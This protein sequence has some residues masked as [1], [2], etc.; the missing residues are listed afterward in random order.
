LVVSVVGESVEEFGMITKE[1]DKIK[2]SAIELNISCPN[3]DKIPFSTDKDLSF[4]VVQEARKNTKL[5][6]IVKLSPNVTDIVEIAHKVEEAGADVINA[7][8]TVSGMK[9]N[10]DTGKTVL[11]NKRGGISGS[12]IKP[13]S[14]KCVYDIYEN[15]KIPIIGTGGVLNGRDALE[16]IMAGASAVSIGSGVYYNGLSVFDEI[17]EFLEKSEFKSIKEIR[18]IAHESI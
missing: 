2:P 12:A 4:S 8:N 5:P 6:L 14:V 3:V 1:V 11:T 18:G 13:V 16:L 10:V 17:S 7:I 15:V 9:I